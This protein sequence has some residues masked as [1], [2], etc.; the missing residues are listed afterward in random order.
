MDK[1]RNMLNTAALAGFACL[2][3]WTISL[4]SN[5]P[6]D[7]FTG[8]VVG[9]ADGMTLMVSTGTET[10]P[11]R[12]AGIH[13]P[14]GGRTEESRKQLSRLALDCAV[15]V[16]IVSGSVQESVP[17]VADVAGCGLNISASMVETGFALADR[18]H[19]TGDGSKLVALEDKARKAHRGLW[20]ESHSRLSLQRNFVESSS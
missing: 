17:V 16:E 13:L 9:A 12:L 3:V 6:G 1:L 15:R 4:Y 10:I 20:A 7:A 18:R 19:M 8:R 2:S 14:E 5:P 11:V